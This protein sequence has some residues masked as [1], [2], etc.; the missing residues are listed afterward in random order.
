MHQSEQKM[1][2]LSILRME[3][4]SNGLAYNNT[5]LQP[6]NT[7]VQALQSHM[8]KTMKA[9]NTNKKGYII[10]L[11]DYNLEALCNSVKIHELPNTEAIAVRIKSAARRLDPENDTRIDKTLANNCQF[12][13]PQL[14]FAEREYLD[15]IAADP[16]VFRTISQE[17]VK[18]NPWHPFP[19]VE[20]KTENDARKFNC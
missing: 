20:I 2:A 12:V 18:S 7:I 10:W 19:F 8:R 6:D 4:E 15:V 16:L 1:Q 11:K 3:A 14:S 13:H 5:I 9:S 17:Q